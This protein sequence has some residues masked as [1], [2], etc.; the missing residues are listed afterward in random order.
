[1]K[2]CLMC[3]QMV[4]DENTSCPFCGSIELE[5]VTEAETTETAEKKVELPS[6][7]EIKEND[8]TDDE[9]EEPIEENP[10]LSKN[11]KTTGKK[12]HKGLYAFFAVLAVVIIAAG[13]YIY[14]FMVIPSKPVKAMFDS[15]Y[16]GNLSGYYES[17]LPPNRDKAKSQMEQNFKDEAAFKSEIESNL[18]QQFGEGYKLKFQ[19]LDIMDVDEKMQTQYKSQLSAEDAKLVTDMKYITLKMTATSSTAEQVDSSTSIAVKY[20]GSWYYFQ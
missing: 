19:V 4:E 3:N 16:S 13:A 12:S 17:I 2:K 1:M 10:F 18:K 7:A 5:E 6:Y 14:I 20:N 8:K 15:Y 9:A 11:V